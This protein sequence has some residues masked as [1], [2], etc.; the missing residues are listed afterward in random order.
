MEVGVS[1]VICTFN[2]QQRLKKTL[3]HATNQLTTFPYEIL[4]VNNNST[5][6]TG[7]WV[8]SYIA[9]SDSKMPVRLLKEE[10][11][12]L[13]FARKKGIEAAN[14]PFILF[15]DD[16]NWLNSDFIQIGA[17][18]LSANSNIGVLGSFGIPKIDGTKPDWFD[19][20]SHSYAV[21]SLGK[22]SGI[23]PKGSYHYGAACFFR[24][25]ALVRLNSIGFESL[26]T[27]RKGQN[28]SSGGDVELCYAIQLLG[29]ELHYDERLRFFHFIEKHRLEWEYYV[30]LK[31]GISASFPL[32]ESYSFKCFQNKSEFRNHLWN[33][34]FIVLKGIVKS[35]ISSVVSQSSQNE[36][37]WIN[38]TSKFTAFV[39]NYKKTTSAFVRNR[40]IFNA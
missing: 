34:F 15:C 21:G 11:Q 17:D 35:G 23:Q 8:E 14:F 4:V 30:K 18:I 32:L 12:G 7:L 1:I 24:K 10:R 37:N 39:T 25:E 33:K 27:D 16:D 5:D 28:L 6:D 36:L 13:S 9:E 20:F 2:G 3:D 22:S 31:K 29:Y 38:T 26:L 40:Q 19:Q